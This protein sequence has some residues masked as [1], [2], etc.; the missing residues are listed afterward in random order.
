M[1]PAEAL[2]P[3]AA[4]SM[5]RMTCFPALKIAASL[6]LKSV[7]SVPQLHDSQQLGDSLFR[8]QPV[9]TFDGKCG[10]RASGE[11]SEERR[12]DRTRG[13]QTALSSPVTATQVSIDH[14]RH[15]CDECLLLFV[16]A[17]LLFHFSRA[18]G[19]CGDEC[20]LLFVTACVLSLSSSTAGDCFRKR[21]SIPPFGPMAKAFVVFNH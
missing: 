16:A 2:M 19:N 20:L 15:P 1:L 5:G 10:D 21:C 9:D 18:P 4:A 14:G 13:G 12:A 6:A 11:V 3:L 8:A 17:R 7:A